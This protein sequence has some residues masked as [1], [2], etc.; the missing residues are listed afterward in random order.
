MKTTVRHLSIALTL[1]L[2]IHFSA[3]Q[4]T[5][6][7]YQGRVTDNGAN[8]NG[9]GQFKFALVTSTNVNH[10][11][12][13]TANLTSDGSGHFFVSSYTVNSGGNGY[14][15][16][17]VVTVS[18]G[19][20][21]GASAVATINGSG[22]VTAINPN[23]V[24]SGYSS[25]PAVTIAPPPPN[26]AYTTYWSNDGT[27]TAGSEP[28]SAVAVPV[29]NGLFTVTL[30]DATQPNMAV[31]SPS[32]FNQPNLQLRIWFNDGVHGFAPLDPAQNLTPAPYAAFA[33]TAS[34]LANG[35]V[36]QQNSNGAPNV[37][38]GASINYVSN[39]VV[40][41]TIA[42][43]GA[44]NYSGVKYTNSATGDFA[45]VSGGGNNNAGGLG[46]AVGGGLNNIA[47]GQYGTI[48]GGDF[49]TASLSHSAVG[50]GSQNIASGY[51]ATVGGGNL[52]TASSS[53][54][55]VSGGDINTATVFDAT[56]GGGGNNSATAAYATVPGGYF[57]IAAGNFSFAAGAAAQAMHSGSFVWADASSGSF[58][59]TAIN[60]FSVRAT[61]GIRLAGDVQLDTATYHNL[62]LL[63]GN[64]VGYLYGSFQKF[65]DGLHL[66]YNYYADAAGNNHVANAGG[67]TSRITVGYGSVGIY[68]GGVNSAPTTQRLFADTTH[69]E[70]NGTFNNFSDRNGKQDFASV[71]PTQI[72]E[73]LARLPLSEWS[74]KDDP[75][76]RHVGPMAQDFYAAFNIGT[77]EKHIAPIDEGG[78]AFAAIQGLN[79][80]VEEQK[81]ELNRK[82]A[83][84]TDL[85]ARLEK[86]EQ[87]I[88]TKTER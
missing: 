13:A 17:P 50:G 36:I 59:S 20:G 43:G 71:N 12:T 24:G 33:N 52:N 45:T 81:A 57:N 39:G 47:S 72:L 66:G 8:F 78:V 86:L 3:G 75:T 69:I 79:R 65:G 51:A 5:A 31:I 29:N 84:I 27:S 2:G 67:A 68:V 82:Q 15:T 42:G 9:N 35:L 87:L 7:T 23:T 48:S 88:N 80:K 53:Y 54:T 74:Y 21:S 32:L 25:A 16:A 63:G 40:G 58:A 28:A 49:N 85:T 61:G 56:V 14:L 55:T 41:A 38:D 19:G 73:N 10:S 6:F 60:E 44:I 4:G 77:D 22:N 34:N 1:I 76:T 18:G 46:S 83:E 62:S 37:I 64:A 11:A 70:V 30:G 26:I